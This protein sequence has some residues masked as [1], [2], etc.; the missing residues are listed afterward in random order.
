MDERAAVRVRMELGAV[1]EEW[2]GSWSALLLVNLAVSTLA[3]SC[4]IAFSSHRL[5]LAAWAFLTASDSLINQGGAAYFQIAGHQSS[6][7]P[8]ASSSLF[9]IV[10]QIS[11]LASLSVSPSPYIPLYIHII[12]P[13]I[14]ALVIT[15]PFLFPQVAVA[16]YFNSRLVVVNIYIQITSS[17]IPPL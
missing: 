1:E 4:L 3:S 16:T 11:F 17:G 10:L 12:L 13:F 15:T 5:L 2:G 14:L 7:L 8:L 6:C 9:F